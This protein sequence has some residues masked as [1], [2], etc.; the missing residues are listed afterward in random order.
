[1]PRW[2]VTATKSWAISFS[3]ARDRGSLEEDRSRQEL[4]DLLQ[5]QEWMLLRRAWLDLLDGRS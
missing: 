5:V 3:E 1:M 2:G 4:L